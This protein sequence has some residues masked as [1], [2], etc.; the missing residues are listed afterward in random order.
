M[1]CS[2]HFPDS[3]LQ[4]RCGCGVNEC[5]PELV[6]ALENIRSEV[7]GPVIVDNACRCPAHNKAVGGA[8]YSQHVLGLAAD[9]R[10]AGLSAWDL[11]QIVLRVPAVRGVGRNDHQDFVHVDVRQDPARWCYSARGEQTAW[12]TPESIE[13]A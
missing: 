11:Y 3:E 10:V 8:R 5:T 12:Y 13:S 9:I 1:A 2:E 7:G 4:C 6:G